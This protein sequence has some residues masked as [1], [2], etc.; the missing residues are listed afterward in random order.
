MSLKIHLKP[1]ERMIIGGSVISTGHSKSELV[2]ENNVPVLRAKDILRE[3]DA[4]TPCKRIYFII[5]LMYV[6]GKDLAR[7]HDIYWTLVKEVM[8]AAPSTTGL[9]AQISKNVLGDRY[10]Q[11]LKLA[12]K[13]IEYEQE[14]MEHA[15]NNRTQRV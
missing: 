1:H 7:K 9:I 3:K 11:A 6:D 2:V 4:D 8:A 5:Q 14:T 15:R 13:L 10:Y 12:K